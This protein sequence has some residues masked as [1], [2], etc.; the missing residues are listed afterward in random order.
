MLYE[1]YEGLEPYQIRFSDLE[2]D[3]LKNAEEIRSKGAY[4]FSIDG[5][6]TF[7]SIISDIRGPNQKGR[8]NNYFTHCFYLYN[9]KF[10]PQLVPAIINV[11][12]PPSN[13][14]ILDPFCGS[15]TALLEANLCGLNAIGI[16]INPV[17]CLISSVKT[18]IFQE[19]FDVLKRSIPN[20]SVLE[21]YAKYKTPN[22]LGLPIITQFF[23]LVF[24]AALS[25]NRYLKIPVRHAYFRLLY[26]YLAILEQYHQ[27]KN[28]F[29][30]FR[31]GQSTIFCEDSRV[32]T[33][34]I[35]PQSVDLVVTSPPYL[36]AL[37]YLTNDIHALDFLNADV[38]ILREKMLGDRSK[39]TEDFWD[40]LSSTLHQLAMVVKEQGHFV[41]IVGS[42]QQ[43]WRRCISIAQSCG[44]AQERYEK[45]PRTTRNNRTY[46]EHIL[47]FVKR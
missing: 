18:K 44:F 47:F 26:R 22:V 38:G 8:Q 12:N 7:H 17:S 31:F 43:M 10:E 19:D 23:L 35:K 14:T 9:G 32:L 37:D 33:R 45:I 1:K 46:F 29:E 39:A 16:D 6:K 20:F 42:K 30:T 5:K 28:Q 40:D 15:G 21:T 13:A 2:L 11:V 3:S 36:D 25:D 41:L 4:Y 27:V 34:F 24:L